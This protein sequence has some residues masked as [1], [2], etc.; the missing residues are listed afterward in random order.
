[1]YITQERMPSP[2][3]RSW[4]EGEELVVSRFS[5]CSFFFV[6]PRGLVSCVSDGVTRVSRFLATFFVM[7]KC[8]WRRRVRR[9][10]WAYGSLYGG[11][12]LPHLR[13]SK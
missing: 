3:F 8:V 4:G 13:A 7:N 2:P 6:A 1:M 11:L 12:Q 10:T 5:L 9:K